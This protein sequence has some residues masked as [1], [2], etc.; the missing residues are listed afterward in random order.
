MSK[1]VLRDPQ[2]RVLEKVREKFDK[3]GVKHLLMVAS[4]GFGKTVCFSYIADCAAALGNTT[5]IFVHRKELVR[6]TS[7]SLTNNGIPHGIIAAGY[8]VVDQPI[9]VCSI[10]TFVRRYKQF[11]PPDLMVIDECHR[12]ISKQ[13]ETVMKWANDSYRLGVTATPDRADGKGF[14][15]Y[16]ET[17]V[18]ADDI[19]TLIKDGWLVQPTIYA[20]PLEGLDLSASKMK[21]GDFDQEFDALLLDHKVITGSALE[22][23]KKYLP[24][25]PPTVVFCATVQHA[26]NVA[27]QFS[28]GGVPSEAIDGSMDDDQRAEILGRLESGEIRCLMSCNLVSEGFDLPAIRAAIMLRRIGPRCISL[29][30]QQVGRILRPFPGKTDAFLFDH[31]ENCKRHMKAVQSFYHEEHKIDWGPSFRGRQKGERE[32][33]V[34]EL[35]TCPMCYCKFP[36]APE[37]PACG[38]VLKVRGIGGGGLEIEEVEG[39]LVRLDPAVLTFK[40]TGSNGR[41]KQVIKKLERA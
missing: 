12:S 30:M 6:Q 26:H 25:H 15:E 5:F 36:P 41:Q 14:T 21:N 17:Y 9:Q 8:P 24:D 32:A 7:R 37:C 1:I 22:H 38:H 40:A 35:E 11:N 23:Y 19:R 18:E 39:E 34:G 13:Y 29:F 27:A 28:E 33:F 10:Q 31:V 20:P 3:E 4:T 2:V 16:Y